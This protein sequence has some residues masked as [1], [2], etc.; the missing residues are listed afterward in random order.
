MITEL[1]I[2]NILFKNESLLLNLTQI[3]HAILTLIVTSQNLLE[4]PT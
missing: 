2:T 3:P 1:I 4:E